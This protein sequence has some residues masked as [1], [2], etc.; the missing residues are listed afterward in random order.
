MTCRATGLVYAFPLN[1]E[2]EAKHLIMTTCASSK[3]QGRFKVK[4]IYGDNDT[5][6][7]NALL[8]SWSKSKGTELSFSL[9]TLRNKMDQLSGQTKLW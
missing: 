6:F 1:K 7:I 2:E 8:S 5:V 9:L 4:R 3:R